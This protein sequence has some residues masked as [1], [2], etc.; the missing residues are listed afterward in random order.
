M[1][2]T[3]SNHPSTTTAAAPEWLLSR[4][5]LSGAWSDPPEADL[6]REGGRC[7]ESAGE[8][9]SVGAGESSE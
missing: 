8:H 3:S 6:H 9:V 5:E 1:P 7:L 4:V 2:S